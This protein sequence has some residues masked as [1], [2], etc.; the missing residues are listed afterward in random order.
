MPLHA[1]TYYGI[2]H[3]ITC[4]YMSLHAIACHVHAITS[5]YAMLHGSKGRTC[6]RQRAGHGDIGRA[7]WRSSQGEPPGGPGRRC[8]R[9]L[10]L[11]RAAAPIHT[12]NEMRKKPTAGLGTTDNAVVLSCPKNNIYKRLLEACCRCPQPSSTLPELD[13][14]SASHPTLSGWGIPSGQWIGLPRGLLRLRISMMLI[15]KV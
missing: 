15:R 8:R 11:H 1:I 14:W 13:G 3:A 10:C 5:I 2:C 6:R 4:H 9:R 12:R 7:R